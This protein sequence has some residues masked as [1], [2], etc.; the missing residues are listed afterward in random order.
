M[1][2]ILATKNK[3]KVYEIKE[4]L[5]DLALEISSLADV[6]GYPEI[7]ESGSTFEANAW[8]KAKQVFSDF[9]IMTLADDSG[10]EV[11]SLSGKP[12]V[13][14]ARYSGENATDLSNCEKL[15]KE[16]GAVKYEKRTARFKCVMVLYD[17]L[18]KKTFE[19]VCEGHILTEM[20]GTDGFGYDPLFV[21]LGFTKTYAEL[22]LETK[23]KISHRGKALKLVKDYLKNSPTPTLPKGEG[24]LL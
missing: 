3:G 15:L 19:G 5:N 6:H 14:S 7:E 4:Y 8:L 11:D 18:T 10:L 12:G 21:P 23:N 9:K 17:G 24:G 20:R 22:D 2:L 1:K 16:M 13:Y